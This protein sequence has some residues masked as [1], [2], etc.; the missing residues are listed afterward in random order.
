MFLCSGCIGQGGPWVTTNFWEDWPPFFA[1]PSFK[2]KPTFHVVFLN[3]FG[4]SFTRRSGLLHLNNCGSFSDIT[5]L[6]WQTMWC[7]L[8]MGLHHQPLL[9]FLQ[10]HQQR[11]QPPSPHLVLGLSFPQFH[12]LPPM[13]IGMWRCGYPSTSLMETDF[14]WVRTSY[15]WTPSSSR[16]LGTEDL[17]LLP[18]FPASGQQGTIQNRW[19]DFY[20]WPYGPTSANI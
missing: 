16:F 4:Q 12:G 18:T 14:L 19:Q 8:M 7:S 13:W 1:V 15:I 6:H 17:W 3:C 20:H 2:F 5:P 11:T 9:S 10:L